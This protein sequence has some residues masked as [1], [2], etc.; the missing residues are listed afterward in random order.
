L[1]LLLEYNSDMAHSSDS[2]TGTNREVGDQ[3]DGFFTGNVCNSYIFISS[4]RI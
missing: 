4:F 3:V 2:G 1:F